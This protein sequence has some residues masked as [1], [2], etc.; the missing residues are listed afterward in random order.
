LVIGRR[1]VEQEQ[2][3]ATRARYGEELIARLSTDLSAR[4]GR[5]FGRANLF[6]MRAF[7]SAYRD[8]LQTRSGQLES[9]G[10]KKVQTPSG[11]LTS[12]LGAAELAARFPLPWSHYARLLSVR[13]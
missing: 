4:F 2:K 9:G 1:I 8:I 5:G 11:Q 7:Y 3:G 13:G 10:I 6:Q 12:A